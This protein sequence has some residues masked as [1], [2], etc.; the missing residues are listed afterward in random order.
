VIVYRILVRPNATG[1]RTAVRFAPGGSDKTINRTFQHF[2]GVR[3]KSGKN[4][5][6]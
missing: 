3:L 5:G 4:F 2:E 1:R 6:K